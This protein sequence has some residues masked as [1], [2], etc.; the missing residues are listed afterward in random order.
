MAGDPHTADSAAAEAAGVLASAAE[1]ATFPPF[2]ASTFSSQ[3][4]WL[5]LT[6]GAT[7]LVLDRVILPRIAN[8]LARRGNQIATDLD[9]AAKL[10]E[11]A[12]QARTASERRLIEARNNAQDLAARAR[13][14]A[15]T[16]IARATEKADADLAARIATATATVAAAREQALANVREI[17]LEAAPAIVARLTG[18]T[19]TA[20]KL[21]AA[22]K[23]VLS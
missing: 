23:K 22:A 18:T 3:I 10:S 13:A 8:T 14:E 21:T 1:K 12:A 2:D 6:F 16:E 15:D 4:F 19:P 7:Y 20:A 9:E 17:A 11:R 5:V